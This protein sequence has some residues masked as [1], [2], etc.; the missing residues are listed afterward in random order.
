MRRPDACSGSTATPTRRT[1]ASAAA[2]TTAASPSSAT[3]CFSATLDAHLVAHRREE[4]PP[5]VERR[6]SAIRR[7]GYSMTMAPLVVKDKVLVGRGRR[8][9]RHPRLHR[10][11]RR[12]DRQ[13]GVALPHDSRPRRA[14]PRDVER[15]RVE[16]RR[17]IDLGDAVLRSRAQPDLLG[18]RQS[19]ARLESAI[20][21]PATTSI[22][23][24]VV[25]LDADTGD[26]EV[27]LPVHAER[28]LRLRLGADRRARR[29]Q[30]ARHADQGDAVG[31]SQRLLLRPRP[32]ERAVPAA[33]RRS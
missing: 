11:V 9:V 7:S 10:R 2:R 27:A 32:H 28:R 18:R 21:G 14:G 12:A 26:A 5:A 6:A 16:D 1:R 29:H 15:R 24:S 13:G 22:T 23:D 31:E 8:R 3:R 20:S 30:L 19:R 17:R 33:A 4:R 25:A